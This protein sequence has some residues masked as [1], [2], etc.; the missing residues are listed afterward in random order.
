MEG[1]VNYLLPDSVGSL[2]F[3]FGSDSIDVQ[4]GHGT[5]QSM[6]DFR[7]IPIKGERMTTYIFRVVVEPDGDGW[8][9]YCPALLQYAA[10]TWGNTKEEALKHINEVVHMVIDELIEDG[11]PIPEDVHVAEEPLVSV[12]V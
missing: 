5:L 2:P 7:Y 12:T 10:A 9:A 1:G 8:H 3:A 11:D 4:V 6:D